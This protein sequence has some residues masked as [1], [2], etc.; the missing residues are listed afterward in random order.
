[1]LSSSH[2]KNFSIG[3]LTKLGPAILPK[4]LI[5]LENAMVNDIAFAMIAL[6]MSLSVY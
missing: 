3:K 5:L 4:P 2:Q 6:S 1:V